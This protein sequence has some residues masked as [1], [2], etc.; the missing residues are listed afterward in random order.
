MKLI[1]ILLIVVSSLLQIKSLI[2]RSQIYTFFW[3]LLLLLISRAYYQCRKFRF[4]YLGPDK[5]LVKVSFKMSFIHI[6]VVA[7]PYVTVCTSIYTVEIYTLLRWLSMCDDLFVPGNV[8]WFEAH[9]LGRRPIRNFAY[10]GCVGAA[11]SWHFTMENV[12]Q[13][14]FRPR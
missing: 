4:W 10:V 14:S 1:F 2:V 11:K 3:L 9:S 13:W 12:S 7:C 5:H 6:E 8:L